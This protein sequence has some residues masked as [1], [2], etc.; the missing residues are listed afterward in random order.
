LAEKPGL[1]VELLSVEQAVEVRARTGWLQGTT[2]LAPQR[3]IFR[4]FEAES[5][6]FAVASFEPNQQGREPWGTY[7]IEAQYRIAREPR[8][9]MMLGVAQ[10]VDFYEVGLHGIRGDMNQNQ[11]Q[12]VLG[13]P[14]ELVPFK[15]SGSF[16]LVYPEFRVRFLQH[17]AASLLSGR[18]ESAFGGDH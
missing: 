16:D 13:Q 14:Q 5:L 15:S 1:Q 6:F 2:G 11:V 9:A 4:G 3:W 12:R 17:R 10:Q 18:N 7:W 8:T